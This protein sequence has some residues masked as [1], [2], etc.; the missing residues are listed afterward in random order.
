MK[1]LFVIRG[2]EECNRVEELLNSL[3]VKYEKVYVD[4]RLGLMML[5]YG[6]VKVPLLVTENLVLVGYEAIKN[7]VSTLSPKP[8]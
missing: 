6:T 4:N 1:V 7:I 3:R 8:Q 5:E 2:N